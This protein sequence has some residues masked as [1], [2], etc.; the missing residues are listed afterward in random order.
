LEAQVSLQIPVYNP[1]DAL[2]DWL[3]SVILELQRWAAEVDNRIAQLPSGV[4]NVIWNGDG[5]TVPTYNA[6]DSGNIEKVDGLV[7]AFTGNPNGGAGS[8]GFWRWDAGSST[9]VKY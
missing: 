3:Q 5:L 2:E 7:V 9:W 8:A 6:A 4:G 1:G